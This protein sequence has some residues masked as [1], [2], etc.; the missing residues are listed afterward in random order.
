MIVLVLF[1]ICKYIF[2]C[3]LET[4]LPGRSRLDGAR[5]WEC[6]QIS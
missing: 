2:V 4:P 3:T 1:V 6:A 5:K